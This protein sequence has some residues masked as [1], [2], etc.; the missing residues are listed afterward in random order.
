VLFVD[1][2]GFT[3]LAER[4]PPADIAE[5]LNRFYALASEVIFEYDGTLD[6]LVGDQVMAF[7][8]APL[9]NED[10]PIRAVQV[11]L[12][13]VR[14]LNELVPADRLQVGA[15]IATGE[16]FVGNV[17]AGAVADYTVLGDTVNVAARLQGVAVAGEILMTEET[18]SR[19]AAQFPD[20][21]PRAVELKGKSEP[22]RVRA[23][24]AN[25]VPTR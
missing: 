3:A 2:R 5:R 1:V 16:A 19:V 6:K 18:Y 10:H 17:G 7:F 20:L 13:I 8:G 22:V 12:R 4:L 11:A 15:G 23:I 24:V 21:P 25:Q 14:S 9:E